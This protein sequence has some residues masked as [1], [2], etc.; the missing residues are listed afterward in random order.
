M[1]PEKYEVITA[2]PFGEEICRS[3]WGMAGVFT[4]DM[5]NVP[6]AYNP[7]RVSVWRG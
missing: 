2:Y 6:A 5:N 7:G 3:K 1:V 4:H